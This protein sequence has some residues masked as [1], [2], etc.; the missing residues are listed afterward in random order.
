MS[1]AYVKLYSRDLMLIELKIWNDYNWNLKFLPKS[2]RVVAS[3]ALHPLDGF[4]LNFSH[5]LDELF[6]LNS[7]TFVGSWCFEVEAADILQIDM[8]PLYW[9]SGRSN[10]DCFQKKK[11]WIRNGNF[12][13]LTCES[14]SLQ[15]RILDHRMR[16]NM[17]QHTSFFYDVSFLL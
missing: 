16:L 6:L 13:G 11:T 12:D 4:F 8:Y 1:A 15:S 2:P 7:F 10:D 5:P 9:R 14:Y 3:D 17:Q